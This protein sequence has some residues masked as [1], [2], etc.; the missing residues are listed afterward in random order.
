MGA[1]LAVACLPVL[2]FLVW[3]YGGPDIDEPRAVADRFMQHL[4]RNED[5]TAYSLMC[6]EVRDR[7]AIGQFTEVVERL[8]RPVSHDVGKG[9]FGDEAGNSAWVTVRLTDR[10]GATTSM[11]LR[12][13]TEPGWSVCDRAFG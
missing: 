8:G 12:L 5:G 7:I 2:G 10:S 4:E 6:P 1:V 13:E 9:G 11:D 3:L